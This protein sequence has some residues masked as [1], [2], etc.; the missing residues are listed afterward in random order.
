MGA[1]SRYSPHF[2]FRYLHLPHLGPLY[3]L[4]V[5]SEHQKKQAHTPSNSCVMREML[6]IRKE[7]LSLHWAPFLEERKVKKQPGRLD[8]PFQG[9]L[10][11]EVTP[12]EMMM[13]TTMRKRVLILFWILF[14]PGRGS[15]Y[16]FALCLFLVWCGFLED[17]AG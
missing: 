8:S 13:T 2:L 14:P 9:T 16:L 7:S 3:T 10:S 11:A 12:S 15:F 17:S 6:I 5:F 4:S 1:C